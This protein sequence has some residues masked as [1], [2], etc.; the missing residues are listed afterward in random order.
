MSMRSVVSILLLTIFGGI[1]ASA[2]ND[3]RPDGITGE[4]WQFGP[5]NRWAYTHIREILPTK[6]IANDSNLVQPIVGLNDAKD[7]LSINL[8]GKT[9][10]L[11]DAMKSQYVD[12]I[13]VL[14]N[15]IAVAEL[16]D[17]TLTPERT[18]LMWSVSKTVTGLTAASVEADGFIDLNKTVVDYVPELAKSGWGQ[19]TLRDILDMRDSSNW[20][21]DYDSPESTVR[22]QD[23]ADGLLTGSMCIDT[24]VIGNYKFL[25]TVG[26]DKSRQ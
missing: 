2:V 25:P 24:D 18:H 20:V 9:V 5:L 16:Y 3:S 1:N 12:G 7:N 4:T 15:G 22:R 19:D 13:L 17:G 8:D 26:I 23:C 6:N 21:E 11:S 10:Q 14:K